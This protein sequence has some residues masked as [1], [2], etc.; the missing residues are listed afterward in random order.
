MRPYS[1]SGANRYCRLFPPSGIKNQADLFGLY[2]LGSN[3]LDDGSDLSR[4]PETLVFT[5][6]TYFG[7]FLD[8]DL[9]RDTSSIDDAFVLQPE[10]IQNQQT[11][12]L[13]LA[14]LYG[15]G[16]FDLEDA[17][18]YVD[19]DV[20]FKVGPRNGRTGGA[21]DIGTDDKGVPL[22][23]DDRTLE[24]AI[25]RQVATVFLHLHNA[26]VEQFRKDYPGDLSRLFARARLQT[27]WQFQWLLLED[28]LR[29]ILD[30]AVYETVFKSRRAAVQW[31]L[32]SIPVEVS[33]AAMRFGHSM[34]RE[35]YLLSRGN[36]KTLHQLFADD[37]RKA[38]LPPDHEIDW[39]FFFQGAGTGGAAL[40]SRPIDARLSPTLHHIPS[41]TK[42]L[43]NAPSAATQPLLPEDALDKLP[44]RTLLR[45]AALRLASGQTAAALLGESILG[46]DELT[47]NRD[48]K[49]TAAGKKLRDHGM[50]SDTPLWYYVLKESEVRSNGNRLG[51]VGSKILAETFYAALLFDAES[52][53]NHPSA[54][55][56]RPPEWKV[57]AASYVFE[58]LRALFA[59]APAL[60]K[61]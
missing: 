60:G 19:N 11:P 37:L 46:A 45:G 61:V 33:A 15:N 32:F 54:S 10:Q 22:A 50:G 34:V 29:R 4:A 39:S 1:T 51:P 28:Y 3:M 20:R 2:Q 44:V 26:A 38:S 56:L 13:D 24:N 7:Q 53:F 5:G 36:D 47:T 52:V 43:F 27:T 40:S 41:A 9:T 58:N 48:G 23:V 55:V 30:S 12:R 31:D 42:R 17:K 57:G 18:Y 25:I 16:P 8:H 21:F 35:K 49:L 59:A 14:H 6:Y